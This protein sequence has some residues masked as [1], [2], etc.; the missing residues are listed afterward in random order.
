MFKNARYFANF[1]LTKIAYSDLCCVSATAPLLNPKTHTPRCAQYWRRSAC[2]VTQY[3]NRVNL[4]YS[5]FIRCDFF[6]ASFTFY[7]T[8]YLFLKLLTFLLFLHIR[9]LVKMCLALHFFVTLITRFSE[10]TIFKRR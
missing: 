5:I 6:S 8:I 2:Q 9:H 3:K 7:G 4:A 10:A 1:R